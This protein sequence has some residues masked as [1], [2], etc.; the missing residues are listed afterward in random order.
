MKNIKSKTNYETRKYI[1]LCCDFNL[2]VLSVFHIKI[3][4]FFIKIKK[5]TR[6]KYYL[7]I[8]QLIINNC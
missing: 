7:D 3:L 1:H 5:I 4:V 6:K 8:F 2:S